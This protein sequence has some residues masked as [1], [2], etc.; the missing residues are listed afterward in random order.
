MRP[1]RVF[2]ARS[3]ATAGGAGRYRDADAVAKHKTFDHYKAWADFK[4]AGGV[5]SQEVIMAAGVDFT[6]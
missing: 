3:P 4:A 1:R 2:F 6:Y 5:K